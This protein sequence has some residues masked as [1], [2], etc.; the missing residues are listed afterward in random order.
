[1]PLD[2]PFFLLVLRE[3][4]SDRRDG[5]NMF[6]FPRPFSWV[7]LQVECIVAVAAFSS[8]RETFYDSSHFFFS[9]SLSLYIHPLSIL[10]SNNS[11][12]SATT[13]TAIT[14]NYK[15]IKSSRPMQTASFFP[16]YFFFSLFFLSDDRSCGEAFCSSICSLIYTYLYIYI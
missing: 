4:D 14:I 7:L 16:S 12:S 2:N 8:T 5:A 13:T 11:S 1:M 9:F 15:M 10:C 3:Y 6:A